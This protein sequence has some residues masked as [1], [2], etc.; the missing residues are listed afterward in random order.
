[1][2]LTNM[3][4]EQAEAAGMGVEAARPTTAALPG[5][6]VGTAAAEALEVPRASSLGDM[7]VAV[8]CEVTW[9]GELH[10]ASHANLV[11]T[12]VLLYSYMYVSC[13]VRQ[14][15]VHM[16]QK[17]LSGICPLSLWGV[18]D[19]TVVL[20]GCVWSANCGKSTC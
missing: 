2:T 7:A 5:E 1:M 11:W 17:S 14:I 13:Q 19:P 4:F 10:I 20:R 18:L 9:V 3:Y 12:A 15:P 16:P 6:W 8:S